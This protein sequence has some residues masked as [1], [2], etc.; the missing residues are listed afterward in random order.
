MSAVASMM[1]VTSSITGSA[2]LLPITNGLVVHLEAG[3]TAS[4]PGSG[5]TWYDL[6][7]SGYT[8]TTASNYQP[9]FGTDASGIKRFAH[10]AANGAGGSRY[11]RSTTNGPFSGNA[12][13]ISVIVTLNQKGTQNYSG[14]F[15]QTYNS[16]ENSMGFISAQGH[17]ATDI[18]RP[19]GRKMSASGSIDVV[20]QVAWTIPSWSTHKTTA[21]IYVN[22]AAQSAASYGTGYPNNLTANEMIVG[23]W[24]PN[25]SG[26]QMD[27]RGDIYSVYVY[28][29]ELSAA[30]VLQIYNHT[31]SRYGI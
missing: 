3:E 15:T 9:T 21:K 24:Q 20:Q 14:I 26:G 2:E 23:A 7:T 17:F 28:S 30:E 5:T 1:S 27:F 19:A 29:R 10:T 16:T 31:R 8:F 25:F 12:F 11:F 22:G 18:W 4:Y 6:S 13:D